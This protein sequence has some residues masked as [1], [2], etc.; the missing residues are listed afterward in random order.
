[1]TKLMTIP[2]SFLAHGEHALGVGPRD[3]FEFYCIGPL[4]AVTYYLAGVHSFN[5]S[6]DELFRVFTAAYGL[7]WPRM[8]NKLG[9]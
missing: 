2:F 8:I 4:G 5:H 3:G 6:E 1:V 9:V 7:V